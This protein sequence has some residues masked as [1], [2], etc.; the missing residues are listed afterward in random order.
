MPLDRR[1]LIPCDEQVPS[2]AMYMTLGDA[3][4]ERQDAGP[5]PG[6][7]VRGPENVGYADLRVLRRPGVP[8]TRH[9][10]GEVRVHIS[11][12]LGVGRMLWRR[13][14]D[15]YFKGKADYCDIAHSLCVRQ[16]ATGFMAHPKLLAMSNGKLLVVWAEHATATADDENW[17]WKSRVY[18]A[19][20][21]LGA[22]F[23]FPTTNGGWSVDR[24]AATPAIPAI[25]V[26]EDPMRPGH[27]VAVGVAEPQNLATTGSQLKLITFTSR[28]YGQTWQLK[29]INS[30][31][32]TSGD[33]CYGVAIE[34]AG[35]R[36]ACLRG[37]ADATNG[38][39]AHYSNDHG[40]TWIAATFDSQ[41]ADK[42]NSVDMALTVNGALVA[43]V[44]SMLATATMQAQ[45]YWS[46][47]AG[48]TWTQFTDNELAQGSARSPAVGVDESGYPYVYTYASVSGGAESIHNTRAGARAITLT[49]V[50]AAISPFNT[51]STTAPGCQIEEDG[52]IDNFSA[53]KDLSIE[54]IAAVTWRGR[55]AFV[56]YYNDTSR[57]SLSLHFAGQWADLR[58]STLHRNADAFASWYWLYL[59]MDMPDTLGASGYSWTAAGTT[60]GNLLLEGRGLELNDS[61]AAQ[62]RYT[63]P[64]LI[65]DPNV[66]RVTASC[67][68]GGD[69]ASDLVMLQVANGGQE[70]RYGIRLSTAGFQVRDVN[71]AANVGPAIATDMTVD[72]EFV[73]VTF[74]TALQQVYWRKLDPDAGEHP[75][76]NELL[77]GNGAALGTGTP[78]ATSHVTFFH[79][80][81]ANSRSQW[82]Q[83]A[84]QRSATVDNP[85]P[86]PPNP[87]VVRWDPENAFQL[88]DATLTLGEY[89]TSDKGPQVAE[90]LM[91]LADGVAVAW[92]GAAAV[93]GD[94]WEVHTR[95]DHGL[96]LAL[97]GGPTRAALS[98]R[99]ALATG[100]SLNYVF[101]AGDGKRFRADALAILGCNFPQ[102]RVQMN[103]ADAWSS[104]PVNH[105][106]TTDAP[107]TIASGSFRGEK[108]RSDTA[109]V[110]Y[111]SL[112]SADGKAITLQTFGAT[113]A[114][115]FRP[116][117][118]RP[119]GTRRWYFAPYFQST[120]A[121]DV[122]WE[123]ADNTEDTLFLTEDPQ[124]LVTAGEE[125]LFV[126]MSDRVLVDLS[127]L[128][129]GVSG[130]R[131]WRFLRITVPGPCAV[132]TTDGAFRLGRVVLGRL[133]Q[134]PDPEWGFSVRYQPNVAYS[135]GAAGQ[136]RTTEV[137]PVLE[138][139]A[140]T[141]GPSAP[142]VRDDLNAVSTL[143][144]WERLREVFLASGMG[145][146]SVVMLWDGVPLTQAGYFRSSGADL[147]L[148]RL[149]G[150]V[151]GRHEAYYPVENCGADAT[152]LIGPV[153]GIGGLTFLEDL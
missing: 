85:S 34:Y 21:G 52:L 145:R 94:R 87:P 152:D 142:E 83:I 150:V 117:Q 32:D 15:P 88:Y 1:I 104:P 20:G 50:T 108:F 122:V 135:T 134:I 96:H 82:R 67:L 45:V 74:T 100:E 3:D 91:E 17:N 28:D 31:G 102:F 72:H 95:A 115:P 77:S 71:G 112:V 43:V 116:H 55:I 113:N 78:E 38:I 10:D 118:F 56:P 9:L 141:W 7:A 137:G 129:G 40:S 70:T 80:T 123:I 128:V 121:P 106:F 79:A 24:D 132:H 125:E 131:G 46:G 27:I 97:D 42:T 133:A 73:F 39:L 109:V 148:G 29:A 75:A 35:Q 89:R 23:T 5:Q 26:A 19:R 25:D 90:V 65:V 36:L 4:D 30:S 146:R 110:P 119:R 53:T 44:A 58:Y 49:E 98:L 62:D 151:D 86:A 147:V 81:A 93:A 33:H 63:S 13:D 8:I 84:L 22:T 92:S 64:T 60:A 18:D 54:S 51:P 107:S 105:L 14:G 68:E 76:F 101:D 140:V 130:S 57:R 144:V 143:D 47:D 41:P 66:I 37:T 153:M 111:L 12:D 127:A 114:A 120:V 103:D 138:S 2:A 126:V 59:P 11:G 61:G 136:V 124:G 99:T 149:T 48:A 6:V 16:T 69:L 139:W